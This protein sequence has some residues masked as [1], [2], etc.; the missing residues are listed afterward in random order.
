MKT[1]LFVYYFNYTN[2]SYGTIM[3]WISYSYPQSRSGL[4]SSIQGYF[5]EYT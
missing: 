3:N 1:E 5:L 4:Y 2:L